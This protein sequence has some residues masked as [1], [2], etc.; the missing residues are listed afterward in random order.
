MRKKIGEIEIFSG[1]TSLKTIPIWGKVEIKNNVT[2]GEVYF[3]I[4]PSLIDICFPLIKKI[5]RLKKD[6]KLIYSRNFWGEYYRVIYSR[7]IVTG[8]H[9]DFIKKLK[10]LGVFHSDSHRFLIKI[11]KNMDDVIEAGIIE[12]L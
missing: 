8:N 5:L 1:K 4:L 10:S 9:N 12:S 7:Y 2:Y 6:V 11:S 3:E